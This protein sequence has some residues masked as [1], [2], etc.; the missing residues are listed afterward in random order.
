MRLEASCFYQFINK[1]LTSSSP[2]ISFIDF[3]EIKIVLYN[4]IV[5]TLREG[6]VARECLNLRHLH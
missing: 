3:L 1:N 6:E 5:T 2:Y 4:S